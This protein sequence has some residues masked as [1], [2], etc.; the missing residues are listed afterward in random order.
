MAPELLLLALSV[1]SYAAGAL[2]ALIF[3]GM[4]GRALVAV[5][6]LVGSLGTLALGA[7]TR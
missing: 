5:G 3:R 2:A 6:A 7:W 4:V 1:A